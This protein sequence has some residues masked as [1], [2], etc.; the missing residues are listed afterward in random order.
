M[1]LIV[2]GDV[3]AAHMKRDIEAKFGP[4]A[5]HDIH[6]PARAAEPP[7]KETRFASEHD[8][9]AGSAAR[10]RLPHSRREP[11]GHAGARR[12]RA[13]PRRRRELARLPQLVAESAGDQRRRVRVHAARP[14]AVPGHRVLRG[15]RREDR[16][17]RARQT[18]PPKIGYPVSDEELERARTNLE[19][20]FVYR[21]QTVQ[22]QSRELGYSIVVHK[23][24]QLRPRSTS[25]SCT[26]IT[27]ADVQRVARKYLTPREHDRRQPAPDRHAEGG[28]LAGACARRRHAFGRS[29][30][31][32]GVVEE[33]RPQGA[34]HEPPS[35]AEPGHRAAA[36][37]AANGVR[38]IVQEHHAVPMFSVR[39]AVL[40][41]LLAERPANNGISNFV[42]EM[43]TRGTG[44]RSREQL[45]DRDR[46]AGRR[47]RRLRRP[48]LVRRRRERS[49][50]DDDRAV[51]T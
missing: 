2:V 6:R 50:R 23:R 44:K 29:R 41:G 28:A 11:Q 30:A 27:A 14:G 42:A 51:S 19:S 26:A 34:A 43:L 20:D 15:C 36:G 40:G 49:C 1:T 21:S 17:R 45:A 8:G 5:D 9:R 16:A 3:N 31:G 12:A 35:G 4:F 13:H 25:T 48:Q 39:A 18:R 38:L 47:P 37:H 7:Q 46:I 32:R 33:R 22:G 10:A 24:S